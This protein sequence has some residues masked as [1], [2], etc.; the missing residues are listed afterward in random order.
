MLSF[1]TNRSSPSTDPLSK[2][3]IN[4]FECEDE[5]RSEPHTL[6]LM[7]IDALRKDFVTEDN[8]PV[9]TKLRSAPQPLDLIDVRVHA[10]T[11]TLP[12]IKV[13]FGGVLI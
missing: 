7:I 8:F 5:K 4:P 11:V 9:L 10:P 12:R 3:V 6:V 13:D 1:D 2:L